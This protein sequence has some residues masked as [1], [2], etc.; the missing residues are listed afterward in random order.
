MLQTYFTAGGH[1][2]Y[3]VVVEEAEEE[4][5]RL[6]GA[7]KTPL[8]DSKKACFG[9]LEEDHQK[10]KDDVIEQASI[11]HDVGGS[12]S[13]RVPWLEQTDF[14]F[15][16]ARLRD[17]E[18]KSSYELPPQRA[19]NVD[20]KEPNLT[21]IVAAAEAVLRD[22]YQLCSDTSPDWKITQQRAN[23]L[24]KFYA[25]ASRKA[26]GFRYYKNASTLVK[27]FTTFKQL[28]VYYYHVVYSQDKH[29]T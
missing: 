1:I 2:D 17:K 21:R 10:T 13:A 28:L 24:N 26:D 20:T 7:G 25:R 29:F 3:F 22:A 8:T 15:Y 23:I 5:G 18:I 6:L 19:P 12:R 16:L 27:Y 11:V 9:T 14:L 4:K